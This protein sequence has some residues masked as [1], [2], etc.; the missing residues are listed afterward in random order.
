MYEFQAK[1]T[2]NRT[3]LSGP[4]IRVSIQP[5]PMKPRELQVDC[6]KTANFV[7]GQKMPGKFLEIGDVGSC[8]DDNKAGVVM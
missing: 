5:D 6:S 3:V 2:I 7:V 4:K 1:A 8:V